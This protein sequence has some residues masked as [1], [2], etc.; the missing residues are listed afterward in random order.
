[1]HQLGNDT[2][3]VWNSSLL[4]QEYDEWD[5]A[6]VFDWQPPKT[7]VF[8]KTSFWICSRSPNLNLFFHCDLH[9]SW[10]RGDMLLRGIVRCYKG[11]RWTYKFEQVPKAHL[12]TFIQ[13]FMYSPLCSSLLIWKWERTLAIRVMRITWNHI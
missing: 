1:M 7:F 10:L 11:C 8:L 4:V 6:F 13:T 3:S 2:S 9:K 5:L 12:P